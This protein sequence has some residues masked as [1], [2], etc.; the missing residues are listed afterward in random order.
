MMSRFR[1][2]KL[3]LLAT[4]SGS[5]QRVIWP[6]KILHATCRVSFRFVMRFPDASSRLYMNDTPPA[7]TGT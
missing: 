2:A 6:V 4:I 1:F 3:G 7:L 5:F